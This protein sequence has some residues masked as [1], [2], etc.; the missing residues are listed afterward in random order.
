LNTE[1][2]SESV[3]YEMTIF[4]YANTLSAVTLVS[5][6]K[7]SFILL[8]SCGT[9]LGVKQN[10]GDLDQFLNRPV[11]KCRHSSIAF[12][13]ELVACGSGLYSLHPSRKGALYS[14]SVSS[15]YHEANPLLVNNYDKVY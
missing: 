3:S 4:H 7:D 12:V 6:N 9:L 1:T 10:R 2:K 5:G 15:V 11:M 14:R 8:L 13:Y